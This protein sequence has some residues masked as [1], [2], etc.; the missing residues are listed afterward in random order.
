MQ[1]ISRAAWGARK[2]K[3]TVHQTTWGSRKGFVVHHSAA[4]ADQTVKAIQGYHMDTNGWSDIGY[5]FL[6]DKAGKIYMGRGWLGVGA[7]AANHNTATVGVCVIGNYESGLPTDAAL[8]AV[9][10]LYQEACKR[11]GSAL[12][13][14]GHRDLGSTACPGGSLHSWAKSKLAGHKPGGGSVTPAPKPSTPAKG[15]KPAPGPK[16]SFPLPAGHYFG[17]KGGPSSSVSGYFGRVFK[18]KTDREWLK[19]FGEQLRKRGWPVGKGKRY[20]GGSGNDGF[21]GPEYKVLTIAF[22]RDQG[23]EPDGKPG[24]ATWRAAFENPVT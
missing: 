11:K 9:A 12:T 18:G 23:L 15:T 3:S 8:D 17:P 10:W 19:I 24:P 13:V 14:Y 6:V 22:Q 5:N 1:I 7:H 21:Y 20:L 4:S 2:A 16:Y